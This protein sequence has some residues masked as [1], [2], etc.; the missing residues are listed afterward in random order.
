MKSLFILLT[1]F[2]VSCGSKKES[3]IYGKTTYE[4]LV[5]LKGTPETQEKMSLADSTMLKFSDGTYYQ[6]T[7]NIVISSYNFP[8]KEMATLIY[9]QHQFKDC[10]IKIET[11][12][13]EIKGHEKHEL[14]MR[15][16]AL[17]KGV[18]YTE[19]A[20][21]IVSVVEYEKK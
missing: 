2:L 6:I 14:F 13:K 20:D 21:F 1:L 10:A 11:M 8:Q 15:C 19:G 12:A 17:G 9:W 18:I 5:A 3:P 7:K 4:E 16:D